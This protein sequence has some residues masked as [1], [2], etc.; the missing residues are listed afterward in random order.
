MKVI[1]TPLL[2]FSQARR[3]RIGQRFSTSAHS[4]NESSAAGDR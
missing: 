3:K 4:W 1:V 2:K